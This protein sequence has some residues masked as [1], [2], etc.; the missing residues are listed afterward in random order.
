MNAH[1]LNLMRVTIA[2]VFIFFIAMVSS[3][4][5]LL[6]AAEDEYVIRWQ[7]DRSAA[8]NLPF[9]DVTLNVAVGEASGIRV[10]DLDGGDLIYTYDETK[11][12]VSITTDGDS[13]ELSF[14]TQTA[15]N[16][17][18]GSFAPAT[19]KFNQQWAWSHGF[20]DNF[21][22]EGSISQF[23]ERDW[24]ATLFLIGEPIIRPE[25]RANLLTTR[26][27]Q[28][29]ITEG[30]SIGN[31]SYDYYDCEPRPGEY[32]ENIVEGQEILNAVIEPSS[33]P[34]YTVISFA[35]P[36]FLDQF[37][38]AVM[39]L[40][41]DPAISLRINESGGRYPLLI[42]QNAV[43]QFVENIQ[44]FAYNPDLP[45][46]RDATIDGDNLEEVIRRIDWIARNTDE[47]KHI[48]YNTI[49][50]GELEEL[51]N[52][53]IEGRIGSLVEYVYRN[54]GPLGTDEVWVAPSDQV[55]SYI[56]LRDAARF[57]IISASRNSENIDPSLIR[58]V[59]QNNV[60]E[61]ESSG[62]LP[63]RVRPQ[64]TPIP[65]VI[66]AIAADTPE[67]EAVAIEPTNTP[68]PFPTPVSTEI[69]E[70][71]IEES[72]TEV[73]SDE[74]ASDTGGIPTFVI[75]LVLSLICL[76]SLLII[77]ALFFFFR[78]YRAAQ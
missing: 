69:A 21:N 23:E 54:Y 10:T 76:A 62:F 41:D 73:A 13:I 28:D 67:P 39:E 53:G 77:A 48:W 16:P 6:E 4:T 52:E 50:H 35:A 43:D 66:E 47:T 72:V 12:V 15:G 22:L 2:F 32:I 40:R 31:H 30:W 26:R 57:R 7:I 61:L 42:D 11:G 37:H 36:C 65:I 24:R 71:E 17:L 9:N 56:T 49:S 59:A 38:P 74:T 34:E 46:G 78:R 8:P 19:L 29:L 5:N 27:I 3:S 51:E 18:I 44:V 55:I 20:D 25:G 45:V 63:T 75:A 33:R 64:D 60:G 1:H 68:R 70:V 14:F 58:E